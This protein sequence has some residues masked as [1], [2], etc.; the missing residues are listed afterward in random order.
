MNIL[1]V[2]NIVIA[3]LAVVLGSYALYAVTQHTYGK[4]TTENPGQAGGVYRSY[5]FFASTTAQT[6]FA[7]TTSA[8]STSITAWF[9]SNGRRVDGAFGIEGAKRVNFY[10]SRDAGTGS[11][12]GSTNFSIQTTRDGT[13]WNNYNRLRQATTTNNANDLSV[14]TSS[15]TISAAT[16]TLIYSMETLGFKAVRCVIVETTDGSHSC[17]VSAD[18]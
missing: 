1:S 16:S 4:I 7:T 17:A 6:N 18:F 11:N 13:T 14:L 12:D 8:T 2:R 10:F 15:A 9:D 3:V 5:D